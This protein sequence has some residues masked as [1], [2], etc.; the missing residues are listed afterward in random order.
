MHDLVKI[1][2]NKFLMHVITI[3]ATHGW[4]K[5][6]NVSFGYEAIEYVSTRYLILVPRLFRGRGRERAWYTLLV[7]A[8][9]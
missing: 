3:L 5:C 1:Q 6:A 4:E 2:S 8:C 9:N 7:H